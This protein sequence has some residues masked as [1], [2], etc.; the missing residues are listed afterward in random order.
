MTVF[1]IEEMI[2]SR[3]ILI[4]KRSGKGPFDFLAP[5]VSN[6]DFL[7]EEEEKSDIILIMVWRHQLSPRRCMC[8]FILE[9]ICRNCWS[10]FYLAP[11]II[12]SNDANIFWKMLSRLF[13]WCMWKFV[14]TQISPIT[15]CNILAYWIK[16]KNTALVRKK[17]IQSV[18]YLQMILEANLYDT[19]HSNKMDSNIIRFIERFAHH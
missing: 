12:S 5:I 11:P 10:L 8:V 13:Y 6:T 4:D 7:E 9:M 18:S 14:Q 17:S 16:F 19:M 15:F 2:N 3:I 1:K